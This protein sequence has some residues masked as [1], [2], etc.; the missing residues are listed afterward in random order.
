MERVR[1]QSPRVTVNARIGVAVVG[2]RRWLIRVQTVRRRKSW[3]VPAPCKA[4]LPIRRAGVIQVV[5]GKL[6]NPMSGLSRTV[7]TDATGKF[8]FRNLPPNPYHLAA[9][10][11]GSIGSTGDIAVRSG[12]PSR[13]ISRSSSASRSDL[14]RRPCR[15]VL[16]RD[17]TAHAAI[18]AAHIENMPSKR[19]LNQS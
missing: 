15:V 8:V 13:S 18:D 1:T 3:A 10:R 12:A 7:V 14:A 5:E 2:L 16:E 9:D 11:Q 4:P 19:S 17:P 6:S